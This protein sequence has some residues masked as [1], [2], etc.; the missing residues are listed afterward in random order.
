MPVTGLPPVV[1]I[2]KQIHASMEQV[3]WG[4]GIQCRKLT[5][6]AKTLVYILSDHYDTEGEVT[7]KLRKAIERTEKA[8]R[9]IS[10][11]FGEWAQMS[12]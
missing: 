10:N 9:D 5:T 12:L 7:D 2:L 8:M 1:D 6:K 3:P 11:D 4:I